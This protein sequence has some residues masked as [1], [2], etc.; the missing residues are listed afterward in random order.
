MLIAVMG[1]TF[2]KVSDSKALIGGMLTEKL[3]IM[4]EY[5]L[6]FRLFNPDFRYYFIVKPANENLE[7]HQE[8]EGRIAAIKNE[9]NKS[10]VAINKKLDARH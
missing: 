6:V 8:W 9:I 1:N 10:S 2:D 3:E 5:R 4:N 7:V